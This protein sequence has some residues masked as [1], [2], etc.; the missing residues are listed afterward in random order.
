WGELRPAFYNGPT[1]PNTKLQWTEPITWTKSWRPQS[2]V[3]P[4]GALGS[5]RATDFFCG[6]V[7]A[8]SNVLTQLVRHP[9]PALV[10]LAAIFLLLLF[11]ATRTTWR[12]SLP[13]RLARRR[14]W[15]EVVTVAWHMYRAHLRLF[16]GIGLLFIPVGIVI[17]LLQ[18]VLF[19][20]VA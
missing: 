9:F 10:T 6:A 1:G 17:G 16:A 13:L 11:A 2:F 15:G 3:V 14:S 20:V 18:Y 5:T 8:G 7:A 19:R 4:G 12:G